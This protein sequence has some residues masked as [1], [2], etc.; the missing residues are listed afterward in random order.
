M[1]VLILYAVLSEK[2][3]ILRI[4]ERDMMKNVYRSYVKYRLLLSDLN[5]MF[6]FST[7]FFLVYCYLLQVHE[8]QWGLG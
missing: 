6:S 4:T 3:L 7:G 8:V 2:F 5:K 1:C